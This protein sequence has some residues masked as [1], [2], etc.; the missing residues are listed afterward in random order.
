M[1]EINFQALLPQLAAAVV[2]PLVGLFVAGIVARLVRW[3]PAL[4]A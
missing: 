4:P 2:I 3:L 1:V